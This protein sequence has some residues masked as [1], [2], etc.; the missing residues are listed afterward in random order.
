MTAQLTRSA[1]CIR[2]HLHCFV[3]ASFMIEF[4]QRTIFVWKNTIIDWIQHLKDLSVSFLPS[5]LSFFF[6]EFKSSVFFPFEFSKEHGKKILLPFELGSIFLHVWTSYVHVN[7]WCILIMKG[8]TSVKLFS[9]DLGGE[10]ASSHC[11]LFH[12]N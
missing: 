7:V 6:N 2:I 4:C 11:S 12:T 9:L 3:Q 1:L 5:F 8:V 10:S